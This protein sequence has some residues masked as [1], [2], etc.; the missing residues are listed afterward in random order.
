METQRKP[1]S[2]FL[3]YSRKIDAALAEEL[4][5]AL[6]LLEFTVHRDADLIRATETWQTKL[7][8][9]VRQSAV[10]LLLLSPEAA[11]STHCAHEWT[12]A[13][14]EQKKFVVVRTNRIVDSDIP[15]DLASR[16]H[17][18]HL[19][20]RSFGLLLGAVVEAI[21]YDSHWSSELNRLQALARDWKEQTVNDRRFYT[22][23]ESQIKKA[24]QWLAAGSEGQ[25]DAP[26]I[27]L[28][29][30]EASQKAHVRRSIARSVEVAI[31]ACIAMAVIF[32]G[33]VAHDLK[34]ENTALNELSKEEAQMI[35]VPT[36]AL[37]S[38]PMAT[39]A[40]AVASE[41]TTASTPSVPAEGLQAAT[42]EWLVGQF[43]AAGRRE[44]SD[45]LVRR[46]MAGGPIDRDHI[47]QA[48]VDSIQ[49]KSRLSGY[50]VNLYVLVTLARMPAWSGNAEQRSKVQE[51]SRMFDEDA[52][53]RT[54]A[55]R[56]RGSAKPPLS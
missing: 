11:R 8:D 28:D 54:W 31:F 10:F 45:E 13:D 48:V 42:L 17:I 44:A 9:A 23:N 26:A 3:S 4:D 40:S 53:Y 19:P 25:A 15:T 33:Y 30:I 22:L 56:A 2:I 16:Q 1:L 24:K 5:T 50:R 27:V 46:F 35:P 18:E 41:S 47:T 38:V 37:T 20:G 39:A 7:D 49:S 36:P 32:M 21:R 55:V 43:N 29:F 14:A 52:T 34:L 12:L 51:A 6:S